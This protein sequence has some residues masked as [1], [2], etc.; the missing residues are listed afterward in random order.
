MS[1]PALQSLEMY[2]T[3]LV[4]LR[5]WMLYRKRIYEGQ[6]HNH[7]QFD[8]RKHLTALQKKEFSRQTSELRSL[9]AFLGLTSQQIKEFKEDAGLTGLLRN[10]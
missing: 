9:E 4:A 3:R 10:S 5:E 6:I 7:E 1:S 2:K 8:P